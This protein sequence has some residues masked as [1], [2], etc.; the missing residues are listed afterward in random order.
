MKGSIFYIAKRY[1]KAN[2]K[3]MKSY[4]GS[5]PNRYIKYLEA[6][7]LYGWSMSQY[8]PYSE[9]SQYLPYSEFKWLNKKEIDG[10]DVDLVSENILHEYILEVNLEYLDKLHLIKNM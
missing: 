7:I 6:N 10:F 1:S 3:Y 9:F 4:D 8:L 5:K 2:N